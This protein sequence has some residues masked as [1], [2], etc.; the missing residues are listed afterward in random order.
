M[1]AQVQLSSSKSFELR[2]ALLVYSGGSA[3]HVSGPNTF[4]TKHSVLSSESGA[5]SLGPGAPIGRE[6]I[7]E[8]IKELRGV[9]PVEFLPENVLV[10]TQESIVWWTPAAVRPMFYA[11]EKGVELKQLSGKQF[12]QPPLVFRAQ[13]GSLDVRALEINERPTPKTKLFR[14]PYWNVNDQGSVCLGS[15][16]VPREASVESIA[17]WEKAFFQSEFTHSNSAKKLTEHPEGFVGLWKSLIGKKSFPV[18]HLVSAGQ[19]LGQFI[20]S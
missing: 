13:V 17:K 2:E 12:P 6:D 19:T 11:V 1:Q 8:L 18:Q 4:V 14:T 9:V 10:R 16:K 7:L 15:T 20:Q 3:H 5:P